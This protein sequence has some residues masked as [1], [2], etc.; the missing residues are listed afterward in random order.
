MTLARSWTMGMLAP[1]PH[2]SLATLLS[3]AGTVKA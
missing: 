2:Y 3:P 1:F